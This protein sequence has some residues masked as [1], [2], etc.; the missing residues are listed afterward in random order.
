ML[1]LSCFLTVRQL[2][3]AI[4]KE[5]QKD[6]CWRVLLFIVLAI[7]LVIV[8]WAAVDP[9]FAKSGKGAGGDGLPSSDSRCQSC[10][11]SI[12]TRVPT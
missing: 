3:K 1:L 12:A 9:N 8:I 5:L 6:K 10:A 2:I 7:G 4:Q 11:S